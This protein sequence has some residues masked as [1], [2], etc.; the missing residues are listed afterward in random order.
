MFDPGFDSNLEVHDSQ[1]WI[2]TITF[3]CNTFD[4]FILGNSPL[5]LSLF[6]FS[7]HLVDSDL[8]FELDN[9]HLLVDSHGTVFSSH[10]SVQKLVEVN[11]S[12][13][14]LDAHLKKQLLGF[15]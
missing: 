15:T 9:L 7:T 6:H 3:T 5:F 8:V 11:E 2:E 10:A 1:E 4:D 14:T 12:L 13:L